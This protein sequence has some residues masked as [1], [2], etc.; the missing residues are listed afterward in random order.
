MQYKVIL[1][2]ADGVALKNEGYF[3]DKLKDQGRLRPEAD[4]DAFF[5]GVFHNCLIGKADLKEELAKVIAEWGWQGTV[6]ELIDF[7]F[8]VGDDLDDDVDRYIQ[9]AKD[10]GL[11]CYIDITS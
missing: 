9:S 4:T 8:S 6:D 1:F 7:W 3:S 11:K 5:A 10:H 2:D